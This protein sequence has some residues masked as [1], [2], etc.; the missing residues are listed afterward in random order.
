MRSFQYVKD[1]FQIA[2]AHY[3]S[4]PEK[5]YCGPSFLH[6]IPSPGWARPPFG[7]LLPS[8]W[9]KRGISS[10][11]AL[12]GEINASNT[13]TLNRTT[14]QDQLSSIKRPS[15]ASVPRLGFPSYAVPFFDHC[16]FLNRTTYLSTLPFLSSSFPP[17][18]S[19]PGTF[20]PASALAII[21]PSF[22]GPGSCSRS[23]RLHGAGVCRRWLASLQSFETPSR[24][25]RMP[26]HS[27]PV[28]QSR[29]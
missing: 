29:F 23:L 20:S 9:K 6:D 18:H 16:A 7:A 19:L 11:K 14:I 25:C 22:L 24:S 10:S 26:A 13:Q 1:R 4:E 8:P 2:G 27:G 12:A 17:R 5:P 15:D 28:S 3:T 21:R